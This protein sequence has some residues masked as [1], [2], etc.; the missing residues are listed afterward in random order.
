[1]NIPI[2]RACSIATPIPGFTPS[3]IPPISERVADATRGADLIL[4]GT[5]LDIRFE[6][7]QEFMVVEVK[8][9][10]KGTGS[11]IIRLAGFFYP[12]GENA[13][14][15]GSKGVF[16]AYRTQGDS[17]PFHYLTR[18]ES[19]D[20]TLNQITTSVGTEPLTPARSP[21]LATMSVL[22]LAVSLLALGVIIT[23]V[24]RR[25]KANNVFLKNE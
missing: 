7:S 2:T 4:E 8:H 16:F 1:M 3:P 12:C 11:E 17:I 13:I 23:W 19:D 18:F 6:N 10:L 22:F 25:V 14:Y 5:V 20:A 24:V 21:S 9:Y 15:V